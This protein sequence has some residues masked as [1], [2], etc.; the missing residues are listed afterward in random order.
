MQITLADLKSHL[1]LDPDDTS[2]DELLTAKI[3]AAEQWVSSYIGEP[4]PDP[5]PAPIAEAI[6]QL[7]A[8]LYDNREGDLGDG[9][10]LDTLGLLAPYRSWSF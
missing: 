4:L 5:L 8:H 3:E 9:I 10:L 1:R 2:E 6:R 7:A